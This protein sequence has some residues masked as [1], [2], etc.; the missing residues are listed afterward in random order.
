MD[1]LQ[2]VLHSKC[3]GAD[4]EEEANRFIVRIPRARRSLLDDEV[5]DQQRKVWGVIVTDS[6]Q[7]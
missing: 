5:G 4:C 6:N 1:P 2:I 3:I 7:R